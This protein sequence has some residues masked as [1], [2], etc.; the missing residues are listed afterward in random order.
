MTTRLYYLFGTNFT[1][2]DGF[3]STKSLPLGA[4]TTV[5]IIAYR[6]S[7]KLYLNGS[8]SQQFPSYGFRS[9]G[10]ASL[11]TSTPWSSAAVAHL[12]GLS[13]VPYSDP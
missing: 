6:Q 7:I 10:T 1:G 2:Y 12:G 5:S 11:Y 9:Y 4:T 3:V 13:L 8:L